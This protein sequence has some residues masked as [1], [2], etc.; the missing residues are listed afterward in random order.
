MILVWLILRNSTMFSLILHGLIR[1]AGKFLITAINPSKTKRGNT[2]KHM[3][4]SITLTQ[5][6]QSRV[7]SWPA[8]LNGTV[9]LAQALGLPSSEDRDPSDK[10]GVS[11]VQTHENK[12]DKNHN[13]RDSNWRDCT[14][15]TIILPTGGV[16]N[17]TISWRVDL[18]PSCEDGITMRYWCPHHN[19]SSGGQ[20][21]TYSWRGTRNRN[22]DRT[23]KRN[24]RGEKGRERGRW[25][26]GG[27]CLEP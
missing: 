18:S 1:S 17:E 13:K 22:W 20:R 25:Y 6:N 10:P 24:K 11:I 9:D 3:H 4:V 27:G 14:Q 12:R 16:A 21:K 15:A 23:K 8:T 7:V 26:R 5:A 19:N 2:K